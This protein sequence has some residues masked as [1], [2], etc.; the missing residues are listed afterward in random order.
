MKLGYDTLSGPSCFPPTSFPQQISC[1]L[2]ISYRNSQTSEGCY[3][4]LNSLIVQ[5][6]IVNQ[7]AQIDT[8]ENNNKQP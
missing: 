4:T 7:H 3:R 8:A 1:I 2:N 5:D 6:E